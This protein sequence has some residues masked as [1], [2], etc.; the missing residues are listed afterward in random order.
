MELLKY[1]IF[2][3]YYLI[4]LGLYALSAVYYFWW[5]F[6]GLGLLAFFILA[7]MNLLG[8]WTHW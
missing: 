1:I 8:I 4:R 7:V 2:F 5:G 3:P 6:V